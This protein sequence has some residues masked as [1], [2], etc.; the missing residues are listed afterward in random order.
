MVW[1][2]LKIRHAWR[3]SYIFVVAVVVFVLFFSQCKIYLERQLPNVEQ[4]HAFASTKNFF[5]PRTHYVKDRHSVPKWLQHRFP[6][7]SSDGHQPRSHSRKPSLVGLWAK[8]KWRVKWPFPSTVAHWYR[9]LTLIKEK[10]PFPP[11]QIRCFSK[12][13]RGIGR[14]SL[15]NRETLTVWPWILCV[16]SLLY[17]WYK[18]EWAHQIL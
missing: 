13:T 4:I 7:S 10:M 6:C 18:T 14:I 16:F 8:I 11:N 9:S 5:K 17:S 1:E 12:R 3:S 15:S 2:Q